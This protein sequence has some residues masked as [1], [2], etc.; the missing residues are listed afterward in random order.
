MNAI[1]T[2]LSPSSNSVVAL[3]PD[4]LLAFEMPRGATFAE[5]A[6]RIGSLGD[7]MHEI[8]ISVA[9]RTAF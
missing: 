5:L 8:P 6:E 2:D 3:F 7:A 1:R 4:G 9:V